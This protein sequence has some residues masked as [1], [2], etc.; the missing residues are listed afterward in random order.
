MI[1][2]RSLEVHARLSAHLLGAVFIS[3]GNHSHSHI[4]SLGRCLLGMVGSG[5]V[6]PRRSVLKALANRAKRTFPVLYPFVPF[7]RRVHTK[8]T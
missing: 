8:G 3:T 6:R 5:I 4:C 2:S 7:V 1:L